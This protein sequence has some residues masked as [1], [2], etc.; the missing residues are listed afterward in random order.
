MPTLMLR[1]AADMIIAA[2][3]FRCDN[4]LRCRHIDSFACLPLRLLR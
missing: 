2:F 4:M 3:R 1:R